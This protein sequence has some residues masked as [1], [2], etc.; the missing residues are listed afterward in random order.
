MLT[1]RREKISDIKEELLPLLEKHWREIALDQDTVKLE[2]DWAT[3]DML[4]ASGVIC[5][6]TA[7]HYGELVGY[8]AYLV[9]PSL[10]YK[11]LRVAENDLYW[12]DPVFRKGMAG[13]NLFRAA[14]VILAGEGVNK[15]V[16]KVKLHNDVGRIFERMGYT[17]IERVYVKTLAG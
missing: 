10:H 9:V 5:L 12:L 3:Y 1:Y 4:D 11:S 2:P 13:V 7:R 6:I 15:I 17:P 8:V 14:E 16:N